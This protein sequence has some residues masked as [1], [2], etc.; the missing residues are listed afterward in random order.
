[1]AI[2]LN[3]IEAFDLAR[4]LAVMGMVVVNYSA[5]MA[6]EVYPAEWIGPAV[7]FIYGRAATVF[8]M[9][10]GASLSLM[11]GK[12]VN[13]DGA[14]RLKPYLMKRCVLLFLAGM[15]LSYWWEADILHV[16][17]LFLAL[18]AWMASL[19]SRVLRR[20]TLASAFISIPVCATLT[21][22]YDLT[23]AIPFVENQHWSARLLLDYV[24]SC[25]YPLFP[26]ITFFLFGMVLGRLEMAKRSNYSRW[27]VVGIVVCVGVEVFSAAMMA[28]VEPRVWDIEGNWWIVFLRSEAFPVT[29]LFMFSSGAGALVV[30]SLCRQTLRRPAPALCLAPVLA[31]GRLSLTL[32][33]THL[34]FGILLVQWI[35]K[36]N[37]TPN[38]AHMLNAAGLFCCAGILA[39]ALW[40]R[41]FRRGPL[42]AL[43]FRLAG[44]RLTKRSRH[45]TPPA[46]ASL[47]DGV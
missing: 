16:Y 31:F 39:S 2:D 13:R 12:W 6:I 28:W 21:V 26:W 22:S 41:W 33:V 7:D 43:F 20:L 34:I 18:G 42:E 4:A 1:M 8:V 24:T 32:Y 27:A 38:A 30:I 37:G 14:P 23:D 9:L 5:M 3:R 35:E 45:R 29:P 17:A 19:S 44:G 25:Y 40:L 47:P 11:A 15:V 46:A 36:S 10:S